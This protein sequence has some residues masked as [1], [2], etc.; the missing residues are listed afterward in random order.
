MQFSVDQ[1]PEILAEYRGDFEERLEEIENLAIYL[2]RRPSNFNYVTRL[3]DLIDEL[4][5]S[6]SKL[7]LAPIIENVE[8]IVQAF[9]LFL[10]QQ[11]YPSSFSEYLLILLD[12]L[13]VIVRD[14]EHLGSIDMYQSQ[15]IHVSLQGIALSK[16]VD[17]L[18]IN[19]P[20][21][22]THLTRDPSN[23]QATLAPSAEVDLFD[24]IELFDAVEVMEASTAA[25]I[26][27]ADNSNNHGKESLLP[28][29]EFFVAKGQDP[30]LLAR[31]FMASKAADPLNYIG[32]ISDIH[33]VHGTNHTAFLQEITLAMNILAGEPMSA[34]D[35]W[36]GICLHDIG[37]ADLSNILALE[38]R[39][40]DEEFTLIKQHPT[41]GASLAERCHLSEE[42]QLLILHHHESY[43]GRGY[44]FGLKGD[45]ISEGGRVLAIADSYHAMVSKR[46]HKRHTKNVLR[47]VTEINACS[48]THYDPLWVDV[49]NH[50][51]K[52][53]W[54]P[55]HENSCE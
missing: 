52:K 51:I 49:F 23:N 53:Y 18:E 5:F 45:G 17:Q 32:H 7:S 22:T 48:A 36:A 16:S 19:I 29:L 33:T 27:E 39:L 38:R 35:L 55:R 34:D 46:P 14:V 31:E 1:D 42:A 3:R 20:Q 21:A 15:N 47:A 13:L 2:E 6:S 37:L 12:R 10:E 11:R 43:D 8:L 25:P 24:D 28:N 41:K 9:D 4:S 54:L 26:D 30:I 40:T 44:P 50:C